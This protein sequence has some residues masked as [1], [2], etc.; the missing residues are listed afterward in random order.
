MGSHIASLLLRFFILY[1][2]QL[3]QAGK[4]YKALPPL[5]SVSSGKK[6]QYFTDQFDFVRYVQKNFVQNNILKDPKTKQNIPG[7]DITLIFMY[8]EDYVYELERLALTYGVEPS[9][10]EL[11]LYSYYEK[12]SLNALKK[13]LKNKFRFMDVTE[14]KGIYTFDGTIQETNFLFMNE[15]LINDCKRLLS[16][17]DKNNMLY[18]DLNGKPS[19][20][21]DVMKAFDKST[22]SNIQRYKGLGEMNADRIAVSTLRPDSDR[23]LIRYTLEDAKEE[24]SAIREFE[25][26]RSKL[27]DFVGTVKRVDLLD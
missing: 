9:L 26:D 23:T 27:L 4:V 14:K 10:L 17:I 25:S 19:T 13:S 2:P 7:K 11:A 24:L 21:Y 15:R 5:Y 1:M 8:N 22:P 3:I 16:I 12:T 20:I 18:F 6:I